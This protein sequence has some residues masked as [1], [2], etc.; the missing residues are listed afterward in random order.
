MSG[1]FNY[2]EDKRLCL[3]N[4]SEVHHPG[5]LLPPPD[6][7]H[8][9]RKQNELPNEGFPGTGR[10]AEVLIASVGK[11]NKQAAFH[12]SDATEVLDFL[13]SLTSGYFVF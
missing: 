1:L 11:K 9:G 2:N 4:G 13:E 7:S 5:T 6:G 8:D 3:E 12:L 10:Q